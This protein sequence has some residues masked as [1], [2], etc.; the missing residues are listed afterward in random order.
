MISLSEDIEK[1]VRSYAKARNIEPK[2]ALERLV[3][4]AISRL[5]ALAK[6]ATA[7]A[8]TKKTKK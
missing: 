7:Q 2:E 5:K 1:Q 8:V 3:S 4:T 6:Y